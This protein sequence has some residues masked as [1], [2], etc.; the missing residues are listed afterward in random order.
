MKALRDLLPGTAFAVQSDGGIIMMKRMTVIV[1]RRQ[2]LR[3][4]L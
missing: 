1:G 2:R 3:G 4:V